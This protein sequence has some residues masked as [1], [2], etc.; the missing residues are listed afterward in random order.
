VARQSEID[1]RLATAYKLPDQETAM[2]F[3]D[4]QK[5]A[6][7]WPPAGACIKGTNISRDRSFA[8]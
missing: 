4:A 3:T 1:E 8:V 6:I 5:E 2:K 7:G